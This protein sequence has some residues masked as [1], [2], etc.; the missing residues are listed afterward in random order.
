MGCESG[1]T[2]K[3]SA[4]VSTKNASLATAGAWQ[5]HSRERASTGARPP[6]AGGPTSGPAA[7]N[8]RNEG[9][10]A[11]Y[12][13]SR[14]R[15]TPADVTVLTGKWFAARATRPPRKKIASAR[16]VVQ[17]RAY[18]R[19]QFVPRTRPEAIFLVLSIRRDAGESHSS[20]NRSPENRTS[21]G[22]DIRYRRLAGAPTGQC[23]RGLFG[24]RHE[25]RRFIR[26]ISRPKRMKRP[27]SYRAP[28]SASEKC[29]GCCW[30]RCKPC[31]GRIATRSGLRWSERP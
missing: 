30:N 17:P 25:P 12:A 6:V 16:P 31:G 28:T 29:S 21:T 14:V 19:V 4:N 7:K 2:R 22:G 15:S 18:A 20:C 5:R 13:P 23:P 26:K 24:C 27:P 8:D 9:S 3:P 1:Y 11:F 10:I